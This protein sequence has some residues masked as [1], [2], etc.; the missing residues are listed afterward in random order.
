MVKNFIHIFLF[1]SI[2]NSNQFGQ[3]TD[4]VKT[5]N[6]EEITIK[7]GLVLEPKS[8]TL[9]E[10]GQLEK[11]DAGSVT[12]IGKFVP[13]VKTQNN[14]RGES[15]FYLRGSSER[16]L[17]LFFD[18]VPL[19]IPWDQ[20][21]DLSLVPTDAVGEL[22]V[23]KGI[24]SV[25]YGANTIAGVLNINS[26]S[27]TGSAGKM[28]AQLGE[29]GNQLYSGHIMGGNNTMSYLLSG[30]YKNQD[31]Y[32]LPDS[33][34]SP[35]NPGTTRVNSYLKSLSLFAKLDYKYSETS[36]VSFSAN[37]IDSEKGVPPEIDV[38][39]PRY[40]R[41]PQ[42]LKYGFSINGTHN[43]KSGLRSLLSYSF[44]AYKF[45][46]QINQFTDASYTEIDDIEKDKDLVLYGRLIFTKFLNTNSLIKLSGSILNTTHDEQYRSANFATD[47]YTQN[48]FSAGAEYEYIKSNII[49]IA[50]VSLDGSANTHPQNSDD[51]DPLLDYS[52][53]GSL[54][55]GLSEGVNFQINAG[56]KTRFPSLRESFSTGL[57]RFVINPDLKPEDAVSGEAG[58]S[59]KSGGIESNLNFFAILLQDGIVRET[60]S[61]GSET[62]FMR[63][64][65]EE[66]R[67]LGSE[68]DIQF[69]ASESY[70]FNFHVTYMNSFAKNE[71]GEFKDTLEYKPN[72]IAGLNADVDLINNLNLVAEFNYVG[73][74][75]GLQEGELYFKELPDY[76][77]TNLRINYSWQLSES[78]IL[79][80]Y[81]R[82]N[83]LFD[84]LYYTQWGLPEAGRQFFAGTSF[85]F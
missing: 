77:I 45:N 71:D 16:Q 46:M 56:R 28:S 25:V 75:F 30:S 60:I 13:S 48:L 58:L 52:L 12:E 32:K 65:K 23:S 49:I 57:G 83:N 9:I 26:K 42:W 51:A 79:N 1:L 22:S 62:K 27:F 5:Y 74:E 44:S 21:I 61:A 18:G 24:P 66:I 55:Y 78:V 40:W 39:K 2:I 85:E 54:I 41:Y 64:N 35:D 69:N 3:N 47:T 20:R 53:N 67:T 17:T 29:N 81:V 72:L 6:L 43:F 14:S 19:N 59:Y 10:P 76:L 4:S 34:S 82:V 7:S 36:N 8:I 80:T 73:K 63:V 31:T 37:V 33:F 70:S 84:N 68:F 15:L 11:S 50:G 38:R